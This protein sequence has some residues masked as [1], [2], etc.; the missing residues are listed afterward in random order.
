MDFTHA[1]YHVRTEDG[2]WSGAMTY[3]Q[4]TALQPKRSEAEWQRL[5]RLEATVGRAHEEDMP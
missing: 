1:H 3:D 2:G 4:V 5:D